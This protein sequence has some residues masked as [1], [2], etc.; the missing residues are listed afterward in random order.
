MN[1][2]SVSNYDWNSSLYQEKHAFVWKYGENLLQILNPQPNER[3]LDLGCGTGQLTAKIAGGAEVIGIDSAPEMI[4]Q[5][6][7]NYPQL[8]FQVADAKNFHLSQPLDAVF[9]NAVLHWIPQA[10]NVINSIS[11]SLKINGRFIAE[12][13]GKGN[14]ES[15]IKALYNALENIGVKNA[16][17]LNLWYF[18]S[19]GE[20]ALKLEKQGFEVT[21]SYLF[22]RSTLLQDK[23]AG[24]ANWIKMFCG[25][26][27]QGL[28]EEQKIMVIQ[29]VEKQLKPKLYQEGNWFA[30]YKRIQIKA[31]KIG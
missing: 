15:I 25:N 30:D 27:F 31:I 4:E 24:L 20:Y 23:D 26:F 28:S 10:D 6:R 18:P 12:F 19:I 17:N 3:I 1:Q 8:K 29:D 7:Q 14:V 22:S 16:P 13:G 5:A 21:Y 11:K 9:S 2:T